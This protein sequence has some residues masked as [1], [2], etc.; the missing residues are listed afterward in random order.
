MSTLCS[1]CGK[2][3][4]VYREHTK[5]PLRPNLCGPCYSRERTSY[6][7]RESVARSLAAAGGRSFREVFGKDPGDPSFW[8]TKHSGH[9]AKA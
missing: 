9:T 4:A 7:E 6:Y 1:V 3:P 8:L 2:S 5:L